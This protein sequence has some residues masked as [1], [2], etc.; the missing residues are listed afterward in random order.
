[1]KAFSAAL[2]AALVACTQMP[3]LETERQ[4][5]LD[6]DIAFMQ[7]VARGGGEAWASYFAEDGRMFSGDGWVVGRDAIRE[8]MTEVF[9]DSTLGLRW[10][11]D[12]AD[13]SVLGDMGYTIGTYRLTSRGESGAP[14]DMSGTYLTIW[15][16]ESDGT[17]KVAVDIGNP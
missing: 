1:M 12:L 4:A 5:L 6:L 14:V 7:E 11:P 17:W 16:K 13:V 3:D 15:R 8:H 10:K 9:A 2:C